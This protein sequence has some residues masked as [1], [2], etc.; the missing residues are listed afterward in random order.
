MRLVL[1]K[2]NVFVDDSKI[3]KATTGWDGNKEY[4]PKCV[5][6]SLAELSLGT[7]RRGWILWKQVAR[8]GK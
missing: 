4:I 8:D 2:N 1:L 5:K 3:Q 7:L 6:I